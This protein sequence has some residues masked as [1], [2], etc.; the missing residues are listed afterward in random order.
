MFK[1]GLTDL[2][3]R[4]FLNSYSHKL[5]L[6][7]KGSFVFVT[8]LGTVKFCAQLSTKESTPDGTIGLSVGHC[9][10]FEKICS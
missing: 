5:D 9:G 4:T 3:Y 7:S 8:E 10:E 2:I 6:D 1:S